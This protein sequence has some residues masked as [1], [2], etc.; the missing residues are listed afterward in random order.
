MICLRFVVLSILVTLVG[1][2]SPALAEPHGASSAAGVQEA[3]RPY[4][5][6]RIDDAA[7]GQIY[8]DGFEGLDLREKV[9]IWHLYNAAL[10][11]RDIF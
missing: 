1:V 4:L 6:E 10:A 7:I 5:L 8:A 3:E 2:A 11:G 9:L